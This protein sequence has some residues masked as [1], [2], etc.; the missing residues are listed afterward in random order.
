MKYLLTIALQLSIVSLANAHC[1]SIWK[2]PKPQ[3]CNAGV[4]KLVNAEDLKSSGTSLQVQPLSPAPEDEIP[5]A[6]VWYVEITKLPPLDE[7]EIG[8]E[9]LKE[10]MKGG[11]NVGR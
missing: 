1:Y 8:I 7:H 2:Y 5:D 4:A 10:Q 9:K 11:N 3:H 6:R